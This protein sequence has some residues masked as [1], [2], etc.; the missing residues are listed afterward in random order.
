MTTV[1]TG[2]AIG[3]MP[4]NLFI[5]SRFWTDDGAVIP[6]ID[7]FT[8]LITIIIPVGFGVLLRHFKP[9][10]AD[11][12][13]KVSQRNGSNIIIMYFNR[14]CEDRLSKLQTVQ[15]SYYLVSEDEKHSRPVIGFCVCGNNKKH[16]P[17]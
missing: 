11:F 2:A 3:L 13:S 7:I 8:T 10:L 17:E 4:L 12:L 9:G 1:S 16:V 15:F 5:Y 14:I 6:Y